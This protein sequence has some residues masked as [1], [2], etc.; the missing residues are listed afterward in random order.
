[1]TKLPLTF[2]LNRRPGYAL[3]CL[4]A[5]A[6]N[7]AFPFYLAFDAE[8]Q[9]VQIGEALQRLCPMLSIGDPVD[10]HFRLCQPNITLAFQPICEQPDAVLLWESLHNQL[11]FNGQVISTPQP[12]WLYFLAT[13]QITDHQ[14]LHSLTV[15]LAN[16]AC[17]GSAS[18][19]LLLLQARTTL[20][21]TRRLAEKIAEER[22]ELQLALRQSE[23]ATA[24][25]EQAADAIEISDAQARLLYVNPA[26]E[27][28]TGYR[29][30]EVLGKTP[31]ELFRAGQHDDQFY[32]EINAAIQAGQIWQGAY[33]GRRKD[34]SLYPQEATIFPIYN[35]FG[36]ITHHVAIKR[37]ISDRKRTQE[38]L[39]N[40]LSL[41]QA[42]FEATADG[43]LVTNSQGNILNFNQKFAE[44]WQQRHPISWD[45]FH[46]LSFIAGFLK[47]PQQFLARIQSLYALPDIESQDILTLKD[48]RYLE[49]RSCPQRLG[50]SVIGRVWSFRDVTERLRTEAQIRYQATHDLLT[51]LPNRKSFNDRLTNALALANR[52]QQKL[53]VMFLDLGRFKLINDSLGHAAGDLLLKEVAQRL[54]QCLRRHDLVAR[55]AGDEFTILLGDI[56]G[57]D[58]AVRVADKILNVMKSDFVLDGQL[59][60]VSNSIGIALYPTDG[61]DTET[62]LKNADA[63]LYR[64]KDSGRNGYHLYN[65]AI[66][67]ETSEWLAL[68]SHMHRALERQE[69]VLYYQPQ[70]N[71]VTGEITQVEALLRWQH[72]EMGLVSPAK[73]IPLAEET[74]LIIPIGEWV[75]RAACTQNCLWQ[76]AGLPPIR[77]AVNL[78][79]RQLRQPNL[80]KMIALILQETGLAPRYLELEITETTVM[81]NVELT[82]SILFDLHQ[83]GVS[84]AMDDFGT[85]YSSLGSL[86][87][88]PFN[89]L[90]IDQSFVRDLTTDPNDK[91]IV[92]A[93]IA[94]GRVLNLKLVAEGVETKVQEHSLLS[95]D[96]EEMQ[97]HLFSPPLSAEEA[98]M[99]LETQLLQSSTLE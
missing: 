74:G 37:D 51:G 68:E 96:C 20:S 11:Q 28:T 92:A 13:P 79:A 55:W 75:L 69:F 38:K 35:Q 15:K 34:G 64:A 49:G 52:Q 62:L 36:Q 40:S 91:A 58:D 29:R 39:G 70:V 26:F 65:S 5:D 82:K 12:R 78:S 46:D 84:M 88:F 45:E 72:P 99:L 41:L 16:R 17:Q 67:S 3:P 44:L 42:T 93:I 33:L 32:E 89:T 73:F 43:I 6:L 4:S 48:G 47:Q 66:N 90:K 95:L 14:D 30:E 50:E 31:A 83:M 76:A 94:M 87:N 24:I 98:T 9:I 80:V 7:Q 25:L 22:S 10:Q 18:E 1:M 85:G 61:H 97:G 57:I 23:W 60:H 2:D 21:D 56:D 19:M 27:Q 81:K 54:K 53:A 71:V 63:A 8:M 86:K 77:V 59:L